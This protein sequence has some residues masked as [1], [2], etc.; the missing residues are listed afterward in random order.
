MRMRFGLACLALAVA[1]PAWSSD[2]SC[3]PPLWEFHPTAPASDPR[4][5]PALASQPAGDGAGNLYFL[6]ASSSSLTQTTH[7][8]LVSLSAAGALRF[9]RDVLDSSPFMLGTLTD[10]VVVPGAVLLVS[11]QV[12][13][14]PGAGSCPA[15][16]LAAFRASDGA[17]LWSQ[18]FSPPAAQTG[19]SVVGCD[20]SRPALGNGDALVRTTFTTFPDGLGVTQLR[21]YDLATGAPRGS[22]GSFDA[23]VVD[24]A[25]NLYASDGA[26]ALVSLGPSG[27]LRYQLPGTGPVAVGEGVVLTGSGEVRHA[28]DGGLIWNLGRDLG[29]P[30]LSA[31]E[32][33]F[34]GCHWSGGACAGGISLF[35]HRVSNGELLWER[36]VSTASDATLVGP[37]ATTRRTAF[38]VS[39]ECSAPAL[40]QEIDWAGRETSRCLLPGAASEVYA[41][42]VL[43]RGQVA[44]S[45]SQAIRAWPTWG[46]DLAADGWVT[47]RGNLGGGDR[48][49]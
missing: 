18:P 26:G 23:P 13:D 25:G 15:F 14:F 21:A 3:P 19:Q 29:R 2:R 49:R 35:G 27:A 36:M 46:R 41:G 43:T 8:E 7:W 4:A 10:P 42:M 20:M 12:G 38:V 16:T 24:V 47:Q 39:Q 45:T 37:V 22:L 34:T 30:L 31:G 48:A 6:V 33:W 44:L 9:R 17:P 1:A 40:F 11:R 5:V 32:L 28:S